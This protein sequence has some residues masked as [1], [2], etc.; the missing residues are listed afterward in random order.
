MTPRVSSFASAYKTYIPKT[1]LCKQP[2]TTTSPERVSR[3]KYAFTI[4]TFSCKRSL[5][6]YVTCVPS[7]V[8]L[9]LP[10]SLSKI[11]VLFLCKPHKE[12]CTL[13]SPHSASETLVLQAFNGLLYGWT[14]DHVISHPGI[15][16]MPIKP[17]VDLARCCCRL[18]HVRWSLYHVRWCQSLIVS[19][20]RY[21]MSPQLSQPVRYYSPLARPYPT[22]VAK[23]LRKKAFPLFCVTLCTADRSNANDDRGW[24]RIMEG[25]GKRGHVIQY[26]VR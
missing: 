8:Q 25:G 17:N 26:C 10:I 24:S 15:T 4:E 5:N 16:T 9:S 7:I 19:P 13:S 18:A 11:T 1:F 20:K 22:K 6:L 3:M 2:K 21:L 14:F 12:F 23:I